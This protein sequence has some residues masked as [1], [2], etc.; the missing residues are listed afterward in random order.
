MPLQAAHVR[1]STLKL[2]NTTSLWVMDGG[3]S[4]SEAEES[5]QEAPSCVLWSRWRE[6]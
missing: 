2:L 3:P 6:A 4:R 1:Q 5:A